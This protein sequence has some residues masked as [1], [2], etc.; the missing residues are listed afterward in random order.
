[1][2]MHHST[3]A[4]Y[5]AVPAIELLPIPSQIS[6]EKAAASWINGLTAITMIDESHK[7]ESG[8]W[9]LIPAAAGGT[10]GWLCQLLKQRGAHVIGIASTEEKRKLALGYGAEVVVGYDDALRTVNEKTGGKGVRAIFDG[11]GKA[12]FDMDLEAV[13]RKG[14]VV[15]FGNASGVVEPIALRRLT[16]KNIKLV[17]PTVMSYLVE[18]EEKERSAKA[19]WDALTGGVQV[20]I[21][22]TY[23]LDD[24]QL[25]HKALEGRMTSGK[26]LVKP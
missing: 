22:K 13:A 19:L 9:V 6:L 10:G 3:Y 12:T 8:D 7:V 25:A 14:S 11:V 18:R 21:W 1:M 20:E 16:A 23:G 17:R 26:L 15:S 24:I 5:T 4:E 2:Y